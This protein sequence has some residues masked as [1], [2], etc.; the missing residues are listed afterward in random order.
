MFTELWHALRNAK[1]TEPD[2]LLIDYK[3]VFNSE[4]G[5]RVLRDIERKTTF[6]RPAIPAGGPIDVNSLIRDEAQRSMF[7][8]ILKKIHK[9]PEK[10]RKEVVNE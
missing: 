10:T 4:A 8:Y 1:A 3:E 7:L 9:I 2:Q 6:G 5:K